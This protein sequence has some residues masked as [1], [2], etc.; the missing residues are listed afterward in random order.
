MLY[1]QTKFDCE[2]TS[3]LEDIVEIV[4]FWLYKPS[5]WPWHLRQ[6]TNFSAWHSGSS[7][8]QAITIPSLV[9]KCSAIQ[10]VS[11]RQTF[12]DILNLCFDLGFEHSNPFFFHGTLHLMILH[13]QTKFGIKQTSS[14]EDRVDIVIFWLCKPSLWPWHWRQRTNFSGSCSALL[15][16]VWYQNDLRF[17]RYHPDKHSLTFWTFAVILTLNAVTKF[18]HTTFRLLMLY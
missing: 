7:P 12:T 4:I 1:Y 5:L 2:K 18:L 15:Y 13:Y 9:T 17:R 14:L 11:S 16:Q 6:W 10:K 8:Y 3:S